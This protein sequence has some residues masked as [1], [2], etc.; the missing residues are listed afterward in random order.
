LLCFSPLIL[1]SNAFDAL[2][3]LFLDW[4]QV[5]DESIDHIKTFVVLSTIN[6]YDWVS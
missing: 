3:S 6:P 1:S 5:D 2:D 4:F